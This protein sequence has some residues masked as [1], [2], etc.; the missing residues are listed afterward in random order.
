MDQ[1]GGDV[2]DENISE[3]GLI[4]EE[5]YEFEA[6][7]RDYSGSISRLEFGQSVGQYWPIVWRWDASP[8]AI[9]LFAKKLGDIGGFPQQVSVEWKV[10][11][12]YGQ[13]AS[14]SLRGKQGKRLRSRNGSS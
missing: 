4:D 10:N 7:E 2:S 5:A 8:T 11:Y 3:Q 6:S 12:E 13:F 14:P 1:V 9:E